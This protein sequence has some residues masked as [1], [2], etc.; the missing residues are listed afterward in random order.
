MRRQPSRA[1]QNWIFD[2]FLKLSDNEDVLHPGILGIRYFRG[3]KHQDL[4]AVY[5]RITG[6]RS[7]PPLWARQAS[8]QEQKGEPISKQTKLLLDKYR[9]N[10]PLKQRI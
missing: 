7:I 6:R 4:E 8:V 5:Q 9:P 3:F 10:G 2:N 1:S